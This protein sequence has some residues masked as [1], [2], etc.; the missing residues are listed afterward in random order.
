MDISRVIEQGCFSR[1]SLVLG[2]WSN[3]IFKIAENF[4]N[5]NLR[6][7]TTQEAE[8]EKLIK[9]ITIFT[10]SFQHVG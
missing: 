9:K 5:R 4:D 6:P 1:F 7:K 8:H 3:R 10:S 2:N